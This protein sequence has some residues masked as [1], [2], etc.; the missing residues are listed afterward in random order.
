MTMI[1]SRDESKKNINES[2]EIKEFSQNKI[3][4]LK[5]QKFDDSYKIT[6]Q[7]L[8]YLAQHYWKKGIPIAMTGVTEY[9]QKKMKKDQAPGRIWLEHFDKYP[10]AT[11]LLGNWYANPEYSTFETVIKQDS[12]LYSPETVAL[13]S[14]LMPDF[15]KKV[16]SRYS[17]RDVIH[18]ELYKEDFELLE[19]AAQELN[20]DCRKQISDNFSQY[21]IIIGRKFMEQDIYSGYNQSIIIPIEL[22]EIQNEFKKSNKIDYCGYIGGISYRTYHFDSYIISKDKIIKVASFPVVNSDFDGYTSSVQAF[23]QKKPLLDTSPPGPQ[24][25]RYSCASLGIA[26]VK[27][28]LKND[29]YQLKNYT[30]QLRFYLNE[31]KKKSELHHFFL[32]S[33]QTLRY[34]QSNEYIELL[35]GMIEEKGE[36]VKYITIHGSRKFMTLENVLRQSINKAK[37]LNDKEVEAENVKCLEELPAFRKKWIAAF[38]AS[39]EK[40]NMMQEEKTGYNR[41]LLYRREKYQNTIETAKSS[42]YFSLDDFTQQI[43]PSFFSQKEKKEEHVTEKQISTLFNSGP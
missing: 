12:K 28:L 8:P 41:Y 34:A 20:E 2:S 10:F 5:N 24:K 33:P 36:L 30:L 37:E 23:E 22:N 15:L 1:Q 16:A 25:D 21:R 42:E 7:D 43:Y 3:K 13:I 27:E 32:T 38:N 14:A 11:F 31:S 26:C 9:M 17:R 18:D 6:M 4:Y 19:K 29:A 39:L 35:K 40:R